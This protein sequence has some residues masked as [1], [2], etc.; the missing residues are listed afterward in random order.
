MMTIL[1]GL[2][3]LMVVVV[4]KV[5]CEAGHSEHACQVGTPH[6]HR[7]L[8][9]VSRSII[10]FDAQQAS[11]GSCT[12]LTPNH[13]FWTETKC[14]DVCGDASHCRAPQSRCARMCSD[15]C[16]CGGTEPTPAPP[17]LC[18]TLKPNHT[19]WTDTKCQK[20]CGDA[21]NCIAPQSRCAAKCAD[22]CPC[23]DTALPTPSPSPSRP[24]NG[25]GSRC[26]GC[27]VIEVKETLCDCEISVNT[28]VPAE[29]IGTGSP[30]VIYFHGKGS[31][32][33]RSKPSELGDDV[34]L[35]SGHAVDGNWFDSH[36]AVALVSTLA[37]VA[38][39]EPNCDVSKGITVAGRSQGCAVQQR[40]LIESRDTRL[41]HFCCEVTQMLESQ[42]EDGK[43]MQPA[44]GS[45]SEGG[46]EWVPADP[47][48]LKGRTLYTFL[49]DADS[50]CPAYGGEGP[51]GM[52]MNGEDSNRIW[53]EYL[54]EENV[55]LD[56]MA[57]MRH[58]DAHPLFWPKCSEAMKLPNTVYSR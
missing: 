25:G 13:P 35:F 45:A 31:V 18:T 15:T 12:T 20:V 29:K 44:P 26:E 7:M 16:P 28:W 19:I 50:V 48:P 5:T 22:T 14:Q 11:Q 9:K 53:S 34:C 58:G 51:G 38:A 36:D 57:G 56:I 4:A 47:Q 52:L 49:G 32:P 27:K 42:Y 21:N 1:A 30:I 43:F 3:S 40:T 37:D 23:G 24:N 8:Q 6:D 55:F 10:S 41:A 39:A 46:D 54:G 17:A 33:L 2:S